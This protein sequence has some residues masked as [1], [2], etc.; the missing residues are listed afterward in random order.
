MLHKLDYHA[1]EKANKVKNQRQNCFK[2]NENDDSIRKCISS[3]QVAEKGIFKIG[4]KNVIV[5]FNRACLTV[6]VDVF[7]LK[8]NTEKELINISFLY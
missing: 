4:N 2:L 3:I 1:I 5:H 6:P 8:T 7:F